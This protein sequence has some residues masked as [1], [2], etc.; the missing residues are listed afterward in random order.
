MKL[1][2]LSTCGPPGPGHSSSKDEPEAD[3]PSS[4]PLQPDHHHP[5][6]QG[7]HRPLQILV[8]PDPTGLLLKVKIRTDCMD[9]AAEALQSLLAFIKL[10]EVETEVDFPE[11][12][13]EFEEV[14]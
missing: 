1:C 5:H 14:H 12:F 10:D 8:S 4:P 7:Q 11:E 3:H 6:T 2:F 13:E 9:L